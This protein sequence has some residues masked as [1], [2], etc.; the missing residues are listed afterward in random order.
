[1]TGTFRKVAGRVEGDPADPSGARIDI[2]VDPASIDTGIQDRD[3][4]LR[5][6]DF[7]DIPRFPTA[8]FVSKKIVRGA[9]GKLT[10]VGDLTLRGVT[11]EV[12]LSVEP[13][14]AATSDSR[15][16]HMVIKASTTI[17]R[18]EFGIEWNQ[19]LDGGGVMIGDDVSI[20]IS[21]ALD[22]PK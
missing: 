15:G 1:V 17:H 21:L 14:A 4:H 22:R 10:I 11:K 19:T 2:T 8:H 12:P 18:H 16:I 9:D 3:T 20:R 6:S 7:F 5:T 13:L